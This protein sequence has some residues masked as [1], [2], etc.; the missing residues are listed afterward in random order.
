MAKKTFIKNAT[1]D[2]FDITYE[3]EAGKIYAIGECPHCGRGFLS[4]Q[5]LN[6]AGAITVS[7]IKTHI[8]VC[9]SKSG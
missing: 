4:V 6:D 1:I 3:K 9:S 7:K 5:Q 8:A 2:G